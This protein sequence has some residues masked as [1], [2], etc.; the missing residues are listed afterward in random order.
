M[1]QIMIA[2]SMLI[3][4]SGVMIAQPNKISGAVI[5][6]TNNN[7]PGEAAVKLQAALADTSAF[8]PKKEKAL[9][10]GYFYYAVCLAKMVSSDTVNVKKFETPALDAHKYYQKVMNSDYAPKYKRL[11][12]EDRAE[13]S[14][15]SALYNMGL[16]YFNQ[17][18]P[19]A[20]AA[21]YRL[22]AVYKPKHI[23]TNRMLGASS[24]LIKD[25]T[26]AVSALEA[27][28]AAYKSEYVDISPEDFASKQKMML[29]EQ[30]ID[31]NDQK[32]VDSSQLSYIVQQLAVIYD[33]QGDAKKALDLLSEGLK[34]TPG[35]EDIKRQELNIYN[36]NPE[37]FEES[38]AK[39]EA[40][41][42]EN[43]DDLPIKLAYGALLERNGEL[44][45][46]FGLYEDAYKRDN[47]NLQANYRLAAYYVNKA[48]DLSG[49][50][51][52]LTKMAEID[53]AD[54]EIKGY[55]EKAYPFLKWLHNAQPTEGEWLRRLI[56]ISGIVGDDDAMM[57]YGKKLG[58][59][60]KN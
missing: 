30:G 59:L 60:N 11:S 54:A 6:Y 43:P 42:N 5:T 28:F 32:A 22:A 7:K 36:R 15:W 58:E 14:I 46:A 48:A 9:Y 21:H 31:I 40:A 12:E 33:A 23:L 38:K 27:A 49:K 53:A 8:Y 47:E 2:L 17:D 4:V 16:K 10:K 52:K 41:V 3:M 13:F 56:E 25:T 39:F 44:E 50:K 1:K 34:V 51:A 19:E 45:K 55:A 35:D 29:L 37:L 26:T 57:D 20:S 18:K 24:M